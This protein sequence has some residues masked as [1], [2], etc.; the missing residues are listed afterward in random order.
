MNEY[1][2]ASVLW[3]YDRAHYVWGGK[4]HVIAFFSHA[5]E[6]VEFKYANQDFVRNGADF[7]H[8]R[9]IVAS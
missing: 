8:E 2:D 9:L 4:N 7:R 1:G 3:D 5:S 6:A